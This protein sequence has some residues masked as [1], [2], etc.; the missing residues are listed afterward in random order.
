MLTALIGLPFM[1]GAL[2]TAAGWTGLV[3]LGVIQLGLPFY[4]YTNAIR[5]VTALDAILVCSMEPVLNPVWV[6]LFL[7]E[8]PGRWAVIG[9]SMIIIAVTLRSLISSKRKIEI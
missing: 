3:I 9:G 8:T 2:P 1:F 4:L 6:F 5:S 7:K